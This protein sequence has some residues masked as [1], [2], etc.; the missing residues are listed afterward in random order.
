MVVEEGYLDAKQG[1]KRGIELGQERNKQRKKY[2][3]FIILFLKYVMSFYSSIG[4]KHVTTTCW[5]YCNSCDN[6]H[7]PHNTLY[8][9]TPHN[10]LYIMTNYTHCIYHSRNL[11]PI[12]PHLYS[13]LFQT[14]PTVIIPSI[15]PLSIKP[16]DLSTRTSCTKPHDLPT[17]SALILFQKKKNQNSH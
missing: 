14:F 12:I 10:T 11:Y 1:W 2:S 3:S 16:H 5:Q 4:A 7:T 17:A 6:M 8:I 9:I 13:N 15:A